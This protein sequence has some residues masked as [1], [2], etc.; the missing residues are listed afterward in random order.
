MAPILTQPSEPT[1]VQRPTNRAD[2]PSEWFELQYGNKGL[3]YTL[4]ILG[5][6]AQPKDGYPLYIGL[7]GG[8]SGAQSV[9]NREW[10]GGST[11]FF[12]ETIDKFH[13]NSAAVLVCPRG[14]TSDTGDTYDLHF[15]KE[16]Y[17]LMERLIS[18]L[19]KPSPPEL[20]KN[21]ALTQRAGL[22]LSNPHF[23]DPNKVILWGFSAGGDGAFQLGTKISDRFAAVVPAAGHPNNTRFAN[24]ANVR[25]LLE[26]GEDDYL[27]GYFQRAHAYLEL[28]EKPL[29]KLHADNFTQHQ[30]HLY[31][32]TCVVVN[33]PNRMN[34]KEDN[35]ANRGHRHNA[36]SQPGTINT[37]QNIL[38]PGSFD[39]WVAKIKQFPTGTPYN[40][41]MV[42]L[43][44][45]C[46]RKQNINPLQ[47]LSGITRISTPEIVIWDLAWRPERPDNIPLADWKEKR[48]FYW[49]YLRDTIPSDV[50][51]QIENSREA[52]EKRNA[53]IK[54]YV[55]EKA[56]Y[57]ANADGT[58]SIYIYNPNEYMG[59]LLKDSWIANGPTSVIIS[60]TN[61]PINT[62]KIQVQPKEVIRQATLD[63]RGDPNLQFAAM[64]YLTKTTSGWVVKDAASLDGRGSSKV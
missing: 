28:A 57:K 21:K 38:N 20:Q 32:Y 37:E 61:Q 33:D 26:V 41:Q 34:Y 11:K 27:P 48:F 31:P 6:G 42:V 53:S 9:N 1:F 24:A 39:T 43:G 14:I 51:K 22:S 46:Y 19:I 49:L 3:Y 62:Q 56:Q 60:E 45:E 2:V 63:A 64:I 29:A 16:S 17:V 36:W 59:Y 8:G 23:V 13:E 4:E 7:H 44:T 18:N 52:P 54:E 47:V 12:R 15:Q 5:K 40:E 25:M 50:Q 55:P 30:K 35:R 58:A 10:A